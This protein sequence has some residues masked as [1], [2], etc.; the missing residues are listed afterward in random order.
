MWFH[1][2]FLALIPPTRPILLLMDG[3]SSHYSP[4]VIRM[5]AEEKVILFTLPLH[6]TYLTQPLDRGAFSALKVYWR[7]ICR[8]FYTKNPGRVITRFDFSSLFSEAWKLAMTPKNNL[9]SFNVTG[10][11]PFDPEHVKVYWPSSFQ[12]KKTYCFQEDMK[13][14]MICSLMSAT[15]FG[16]V[17]F[18]LTYFKVHVSLS[19]VLLYI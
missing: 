8:D 2:H 1:K 7:Q 17:F 16:S 13:M 5:A 4:D 19:A 18:I 9:S 15:I 10:V 12:Q 14:S 6:T 11:Y 3:H